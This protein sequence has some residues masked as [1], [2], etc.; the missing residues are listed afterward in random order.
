MIFKNGFPLLEKLLALR[1]RTKT[2]FAKVKALSK[3][4][5]LPNGF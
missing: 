3:N 1:V 4:P 5:M 2:T